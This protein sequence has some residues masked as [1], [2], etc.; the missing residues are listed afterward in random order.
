MDDAKIIIGGSTE[1]DAAAFLDA[2][3]RAERGEKIRE[4]V[5]AFESLEALAQ[6]TTKDTA[7]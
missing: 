7:D 4:R 2:W 3:H 1:D 6:S 5:L